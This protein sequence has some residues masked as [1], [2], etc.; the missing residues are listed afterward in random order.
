MLFLFLALKHMLLPSPHWR[1]C[2]GGL[3]CRYAAIAGPVL[4]DP[5]LFGDYST[6]LQDSDAAPDG[7]QLRLY[8]DVG[9]YSSIQRLFEG[10][11]A[12]Y[13][14]KHKPMNLVFFDDALE[15]LTRIHRTLRLPLVGNSLLRAPRLQLSLV[16]RHLHM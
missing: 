7:P 10:V 13:N 15:H 11:L 5:I 16:H 12:A 9:S 2:C 3:F 8:Q 1:C 6:I 4:A 14:E